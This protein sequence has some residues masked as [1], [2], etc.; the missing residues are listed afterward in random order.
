M[1]EDKDVTKIKEV[2]VVVAMVAATRAAKTAIS[3]ARSATSR[4]TRRG[5]AGIAT[6]T[7][8]KKRRRREQMLLPTGWTPTGMAT[9][10]PPTTSP[11]SLTSSP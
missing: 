11:V 7:M 1:A 5:D 3:S 10:V 2:V 9:L 4:D 6:P 8:K